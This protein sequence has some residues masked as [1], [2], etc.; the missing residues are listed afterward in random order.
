MEYD[1]DDA[2]PKEG[3]NTEDEAWMVGWDQNGETGCGIEWIQLAQDRKRG[4]FF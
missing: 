3:N 2:G 1:D 4:W